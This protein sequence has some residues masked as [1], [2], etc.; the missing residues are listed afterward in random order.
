MKKK[1]SMSMKVAL[2]HFVSI[3]RSGQKQFNVLQQRYH[4]A[5]VIT[6]ILHLVVAQLYKAKNKRVTCLNCVRA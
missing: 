3:S 4:G 5:M 2:V 1:N 6:N